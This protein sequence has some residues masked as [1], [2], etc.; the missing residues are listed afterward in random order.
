MQR[1]RKA[2]NAGLVGEFSEHESHAKMC[3]LGGSIEILVADHRYVATR[4]QRE[5]QCKVF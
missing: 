4:K 2:A 3:T 5:M 1:T